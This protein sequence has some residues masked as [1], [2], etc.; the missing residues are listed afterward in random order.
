LQETEV[1]LLALDGALSTRSCVFVRLPQVAISRN[2]CVQA[3]VLLRIG[4]DD[5]AIGRIGAAIGKMGGKRTQEGF[6]W[7]QLAGNAT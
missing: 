6:S 4:V 3:I 5:A 2:E 1:I 7:K